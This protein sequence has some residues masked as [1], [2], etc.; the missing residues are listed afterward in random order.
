MNIDYSKFNLEV[1]DNKIVNIEEVLEYLNQSNIDESLEIFLETLL[2]KVKYTE[3]NNKDIL[4][5][6]ISSKLLQFQALQES[7]NIS[8]AASLRA[9]QEK[10]DDLKKINIIETS[11]ET[12]DSQ[13]DIDYITFTNDDG[14]VE[15]LVCAGKNTLNTYIQQHSDEI[16]NLSARDIFNHF[17]K[18]IHQELKFYNEEEM[19]NNTEL[20][21][22]AVVREE[23]T[24]KQEMEVLEEYAKKYGLYEKIE[25]TI[26]PNGERLYRVGD[27]L[28][29]FRTL[30]EKR[31]LETLV[32]PN[33]NKTNTEDLLD[34]LDETPSIAPTVSNN[35]SEARKVD[36]YDTIETIGYHE[37][38][39][40]DFI[41]ITRKRD[42]Y[43]VELTSDEL[44]RL[45][46]YIKFLINNMIEMAKN[47]D[48]E[49]YDMLSSYM[50]SA[51]KDQPSIIDTYKE[52]QEGLQ[53]PNKLSELDTEFAKRYLDNL[54]YIKSLNLQKNKNRIL[55]LKPDKQ[56]GIATLVLLL[57][58]AVLAMFILMFLS[59]DI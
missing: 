20:G 14:T 53:S 54:N 33:I 9:M 32:Q 59:L 10:N 23:Q 11:K 18:Y 55:E 1:R 28:F 31:E 25:I 27:G 4:I 44:H 48:D 57:E 56:S 45:N 35:I 15:V 47:N 2:A 12:N 50:E 24:K 36:T 51:D 40:E 41:D 49:F 46:V 29:K 7:A 39:K 52:I 16:T 21:N 30:G 8:N 3:F 22:T 13:K 17:K 6:A 5:G 38:D 26:D 34:E 19:N 43:E 58:I 37:F 42:I